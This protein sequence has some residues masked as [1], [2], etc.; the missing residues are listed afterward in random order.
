MGERRSF[1]VGLGVAGL[2]ASMFFGM[3]ALS[4]ALA[5]EAAPAA[6][7]AAVQPGAPA[8]A[9]APEPAAAPKEEIDETA[10]MIQQLKA[11]GKTGIALLLASIAGFA[12]AFERLFNLRRAKI[13]PMGF[14][15][16][17]DSL[18]KS[19]DF[20]GL[21]RLCKSQPSTFARVIKE[22][23]EHRKAPRVDI[24]QMAG[25]VAS[26][27][28]KLHL[29]RAYPLAVV[30]TISPLLGLFGTVYGM[31]GAFR[32][33]A[34]A[35]KMGDP[36]IMASDIAFALVTTAVGLVIAIPALSA[37]HF[38]RVRT[39]IFSLNLEEQS[40]HLIDR[41]CGLEVESPAQTD[42]A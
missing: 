18:W 34:L 24:A 7:P 8:A 5:D 19:G 31:M 2:A 22:I 39:H 41:W 33:V 38:F 29:Q 17:A 10:E 4:S 1:W 25:D 11:C 30:A 12:F 35:G 16:K 14:A 9:P 20:D 3:T 28:M 21:L 6:V 26:R 27:E 42:K 40:S 37:Y 32:S 15:S 13:I 23:V 36:S